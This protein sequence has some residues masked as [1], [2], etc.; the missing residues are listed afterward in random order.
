M[1]ASPKFQTSSLKRWTEMTA[2]MDVTK[3]RIMSAEETGKRAAPR[4]FLVLYL[5]L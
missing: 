1:G 4:C 5:L 3:S 2:K